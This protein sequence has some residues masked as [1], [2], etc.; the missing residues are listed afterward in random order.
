M[1]RIENYTYISL[2]FI[3]LL[4]ELGRHFELERKLALKCGSVEAE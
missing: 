1:Q 4:H 3:G 2:A